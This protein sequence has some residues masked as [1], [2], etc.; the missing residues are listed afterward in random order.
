MRSAPG[1]ILG[2]GR[3]SGEGARK[4]IAICARNGVTERE[5]ELLGPEA[6]VSSAITLKKSPSKDRILQP[7][8]EVLDEC[9]E[10][11]SFDKWAR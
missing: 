11:F 4:E 1:I 9:C 8:P 5:G 7:T 3:V 2:Q 10:S 6:N